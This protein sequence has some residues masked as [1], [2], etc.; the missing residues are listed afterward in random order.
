[1]SEE[2]GGLVLASNRGQKPYGMRANQALQG[3]DIRSVLAI[4]IL[5]LFGLVVA[6]VL[7]IALNTPEIDLKIV[8]LS[9]ESYV[10]ELA[11]LEIFGIS[12]ISASNRLS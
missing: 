2:A 12:R 5:V 8:E 6:L 10:K 1:M 7:G 11:D 3:R 4:F 9:H